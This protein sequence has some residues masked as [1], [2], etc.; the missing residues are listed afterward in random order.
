MSVIEVSFEVS[1][2][3]AAGYGR[4]KSLKWPWLYDQLRAKGYTKEKAAA[5]SNSRLKF[6]KKGR[7]NVL[8]AKQAHDP[9]VLKRIS[10][11]GRHPTKRELLRPNG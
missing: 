8:T 4:S 6:R 2:L 5:I 10:S 3:T 11:A 1:E 7:K 9:A